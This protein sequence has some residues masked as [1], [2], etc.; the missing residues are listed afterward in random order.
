[1]TSGIFVASRNKKLFRLISFGRRLGA[2]GFNIPALIL[3]ADR[4]RL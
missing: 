3:A 2:P 1:L 4:F